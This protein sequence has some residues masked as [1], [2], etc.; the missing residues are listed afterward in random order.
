M[1]IH[2]SH[3]PDSHSNFQILIFLQRKNSQSLEPKKKLDGLECRIWLFIPQIPHK[4]CFYLE[5][6]YFLGRW[7]RLRMHCII[8]S[9]IWLEVIQ[10]VMVKMLKLL[11]NL[12]LL[13][14]N[15]SKS[16]AILLLLQ[17]RTMNSLS[18]HKKCLQKS[19]DHLNQYRKFL[20]KFKHLTEALLLFPPPVNPSKLTR[21]FSNSSQIFMNKTKNNKSTTFLKTPSLQHLLN[22]HPCFLSQLTKK[23]KK[24]DWS[25][26]SNP[27]IALTPSSRFLVIESNNS[28]NDNSNK[29]K[30]P[31]FSFVSTASHKIQPVLPQRLDWPFFNKLQP[32]FEE[33]IRRFYVSIDVTNQL[34]A[35]YP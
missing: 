8:T 1:L 4:S 23:S 13:H 19:K 26:Y 31:L 20:Q 14:N 22:I 10:S 34:L 35:L 9:K 27:S 24:Q 21:L 30:S 12:Y 32:T 18:Q 28:T 2:Q 3:T 25:P 11:L 29:K 15:Q 6:V 16:K 17:N 33:L 5:V 7:T